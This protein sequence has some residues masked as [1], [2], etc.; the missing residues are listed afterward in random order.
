MTQQAGQRLAIVGMYMRQQQRQVGQ[1]TRRHA[2][3]RFMRLPVETFRP[4]RQAKKAGW[5]ACNR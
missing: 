3:N 2:E 1:L 4:G 5:R